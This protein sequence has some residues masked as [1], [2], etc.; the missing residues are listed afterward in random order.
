M[1]VVE[2]RS[3]VEIF[4]LGI[5]P[6][7]VVMSPS[8]KIYNDIMNFIHSSGNQSFV[9]IVLEIGE[10]RNRGIISES[11]A[12]LML[13]TLEFVDATNPKIVIESYKKNNSK[14]N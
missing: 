11:R 13:L 8:D 12:K 14:T 10:F 7:Q 1:A 4:K 6:E 3:E 2:T 9:D 5:A